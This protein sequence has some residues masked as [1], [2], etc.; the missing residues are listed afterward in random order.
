MLPN[1]ED[2]SV[3]KVRKCYLILNT[4]LLKSKEVLPNPEDLSG[5]GQVETGNK[6]VAGGPETEGQHGHAP[7][8]PKRRGLY[9][10]S[11]VIYSLIAFYLG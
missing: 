10:D 6:D 4:Y 9:R 11:S 8:K 7:A 5:S 2:L 3:Y 1:P